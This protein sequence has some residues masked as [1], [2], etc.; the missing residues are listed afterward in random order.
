MEDELNVS[1]IRLHLQEL[2]WAKQCHN[3]V[4]YTLC[5]RTRDTELHCIKSQLSLVPGVMEPV[6]AFA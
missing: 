5:R 1:T 4:P 2:F 6:S 3:G